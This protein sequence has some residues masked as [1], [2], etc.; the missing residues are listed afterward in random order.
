MN[1]SY[2]VEAPGMVRI[3]P[4]MEGIITAQRYV[5]IAR[6]LLANGLLSNDEKLKDES[7]L[8]LSDNLTL[9]MELREKGP[10]EVRQVI[11]SMYGRDYIVNSN[12]I[13]TIFSKKP[14]SAIDEHNRVASE[15]I[16]EISEDIR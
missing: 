12:N 8:D 3:V 2:K 9:Y 11:F 7:S 1:I 14:E 6:D 16:Q 4:S 10:S 5:E 15:I 13:N